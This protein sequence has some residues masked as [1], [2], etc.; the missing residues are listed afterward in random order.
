[1]KKT[2]FLGVGSYSEVLPSQ[3]DY[4][5]WYRI[6]LAGNPIAVASVPLVAKRLHEQQS[7]ERGNRIQ[8]ILNSYKVQS[9]V[10]S[11]MNGNW[12]D[13]FFMIIRLLR[14]LVPAKIRLSLR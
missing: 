1:M 8:Y 4:E 9:M 2:L 3:I 7:F 12:C 13:K 6:Y 5:L 10:I 14:G 11:G